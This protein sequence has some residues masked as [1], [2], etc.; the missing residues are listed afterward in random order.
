MA[1]KIKNIDPTTLYIDNPVAE[2]NR[3]QGLQKK[4]ADKVTWLE[5]AFGVAYR[6]QKRRVDEG[7][8]PQ[9]YLGNNEYISVFPDDSVSGMCFFDVEDTIALTGDAKRNWTATINIIF[10][11]N[12]ET[13]YP[14]LTHRADAEARQSV[15]N[16]LFKYG[17]GWTINNIV[18]GV[19]NVYDR[20]NW[21]S[22]HA[23]IDKNPF[24][25]F[26]LECEVTYDCYKY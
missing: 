9:I 21:N 15:I 4:L 20:Y 14:T 24:H 23:K 7:F 18:K 2:Y 26:S 22:P 3:V 6:E 16:V 11:V 13:A 19:D 1:T 5:K 12:L 25:V 8:E 10:F 17:H